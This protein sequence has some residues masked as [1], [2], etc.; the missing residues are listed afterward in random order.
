MISVERIIWLIIN[1]I[2][3]LISI[4]ILHFIW[5]YLDSKP[6]G[7]QSLFDLTLKGIIQGFVMHMSTTWFVFLRYSDSYSYT[8]TLAIL[9][10]WFS[11][12][13][14]TYLWGMVLLFTRYLVVFHNHMLDR[15]EDEKFIWVM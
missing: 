3:Q 5:N 8:L 2:S 7:M 11:T 6:L 9:M 15:F 1:G 13:L 4:I 10:A 14:W 12:L